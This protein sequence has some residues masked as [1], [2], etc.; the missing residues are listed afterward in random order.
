MREKK[1]WHEEKIGQNCKKRSATV[2][3][4]SNNPGRT[5]QNRMSKKRVSFETQ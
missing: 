2:T 4:A 3:G 1:K 5:R